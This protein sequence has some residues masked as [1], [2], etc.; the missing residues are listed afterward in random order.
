MDFKFFMP[1]D[2]R[3]GEDALSSLCLELNDKN[4]FVVT[5]KI[6]LEK[7]VVNKAISTFNPKKITVFDKVEP[8]P[9]TET[10]NRAASL[11]REKNID[12]VLA[13]G[14]G[15]AMD[16][17]K[18]VAILITNDGSIEDYIKGKAYKNA[19]AC[20]IC[21]PTTA[22]TGSEVTCVSVLTN[23][24]SNTKIPLVSNMLWPRFA[25]VVPSLTLSMPKHITAETGWDAFSHALEAYW[26]KSSNPISDALALK[27]IELIL[28]NIEIAYMNA[29]D[30]VA[31]SKMCLASLIAGIAFSQT[32]TTA[33]HATS[34]M[35]TSDYKLSHG[36]ACA[37]TILAFL[38]YCNGYWD[39]KQN[40]LLKYLKI[41]SFDKF[42]TILQDKLIRT[43]MPIKFS[44]IGITNDDITALAQSASNY[45]ILHEIPRKI[46]IDS[47]KQILTNNI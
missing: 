15:S 47:L 14:G 22:G 44:N 12:A 18:C 34:F 1:V 4:V 20:L 38:D 40:Y 42:K 24:A 39:E 46:T 26:S 37:I 23:K 32:R 3:Y 17:A 7:G 21:A 6:L 27:S 31:R 9:S 35:L 5:D 11:A 30:I 41:E 19:P 25:C 28:D 2:I 45:A 13:I 36:R 33:I 8:N 43:Q 29:S 16:T 10:I